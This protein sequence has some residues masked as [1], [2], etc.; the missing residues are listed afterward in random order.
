MLKKTILSLA[1]GWTFLIL[2]VCLVNFNDLPT[3]KVSGYDKYG[4]FTFHFLFILLWGYYAW[5]KQN[6]IRFR[7]LIHILL[8]SVCYGILIE[9]L[10]ETCTKTRHADILDILANFTGAMTGFV[11]FV[12]IKKVKKD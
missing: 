5:L 11:V 7:K 3:I 2:V 4:H 8:I 10:Q 9:F 12:L 1:I 6:H